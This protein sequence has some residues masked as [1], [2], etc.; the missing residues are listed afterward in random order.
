MVSRFGRT[1]FFRLGLLVLWEDLVCK[2]ALWYCQY[3]PQQLSTNSSSYLECSS[4]A[5]NTVVRLLGWQA[6]ERREDGLGLLGNQVVGSARECLLVVFR[7]RRI[8]KR[9]K[10]MSHAD[11][12]RFDGRCVALSYLRPNCLYP[13]ASEYQLANGCIHL[14]N[15]GRLTMKLVIEGCDMFAVFQLSPTAVDV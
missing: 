12:A 9:L 8:G 14:L 7:S 10:V 15:Q 2:G 3:T 6:L 5:E 13:A 4:H 1:Y 11:S